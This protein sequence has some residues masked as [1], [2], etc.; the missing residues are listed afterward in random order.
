MVTHAMIWYL[1]NDH[2][3]P[4]SEF[5]PTLGI[6]IL[7]DGTSDVMSLLSHPRLGPYFL[8]FAVG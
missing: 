7:D 4:V 3:F 6:E 1:K 8:N 5:C 2:Y